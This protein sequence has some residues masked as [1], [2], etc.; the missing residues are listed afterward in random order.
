MEGDDQVRALVQQHPRVAL[1]T[2]KPP[3]RRPGQALGLPID[4]MATMPFRAQTMNLFQ[5]G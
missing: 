3:V 4:R 2:G 5:P 1:R